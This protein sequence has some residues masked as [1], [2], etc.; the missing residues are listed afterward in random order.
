MLYILIPAYNEENNIIPLFN[1]IA[2]NLKDYPHKIVLVDDGSTDRTLELASEYKNDKESITILSHNRN[3]GVG[4]A[5][6]TGLSYI[7]EHATEKDHLI[8]MEADQTS[9]PDMIL[10][11]LDKLSNSY[12]VVIASRLIGKGGY[13]G[14]P[15]YRKFLSIMANRW[16]SFVY[17]LEKDIDATIFYRAYH[18]QPIK[19][20]FSKYKTI[21]SNIKGFAINATLLYFLIKENYKVA[22][23]PFIYNYHYKMSESK[24]KILS[25]IQEY[26]IIWKTISKAKSKLK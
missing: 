22:S 6:F 1:S 21:L 9:D 24:I 14:F 19:T 12:D 2:V 26:I 10:D 7:F 15:P 8:I 18:I 11:L 17:N 3:L 23:I 25:T 20:I 16:L 4:A 13:Q 5:F